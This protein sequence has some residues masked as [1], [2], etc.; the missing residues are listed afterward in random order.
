[1]EKRIDYRFKHASIAERALTHRSS[2]QREKLELIDSNEQLE[3]LGDSVL[4]LVASEYILEKYPHFG[5][6]RL[7]QIKSLIVSG[8]VLSQ[9]ARHI[10]LGAFLLMGVGEIRSGGRTRPSILE[11][12]FEAL[13][14]AIYLDG[15]LKAAR[16]FIRQ[17]LL[18]RLEEICESDDLRNYKS[19]L[20]EYTQSHSSK[21][22]VYRV[23]SEEGPDHQKNYKIEVLI[24]GESFGFGE[25][26]CKKRAEQ[27]AARCALLKLGVDLSNLNDH[28]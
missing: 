19:I 21:Q 3:F 25:G 22:P 12:A 5:E 16:K 18:T 24:S 7:T 26:T 14:G 15:G 8:E 28:D 23:I 13:V 27:L 17:H 20:L 9:S 10:D 4:G 6:G 2:L 11:D 1:L